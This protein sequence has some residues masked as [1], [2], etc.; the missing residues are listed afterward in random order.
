MF[1]VEKYSYTISWV[2]MCHVLITTEL[3]VLP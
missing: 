2:M 1:C 3:M